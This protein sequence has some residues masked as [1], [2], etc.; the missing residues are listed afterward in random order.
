MSDQ[1][2]SAQADIARRALEEVCSSRN[3]A[4]FHE[5]YAES[6][7]D[8]VNSA[9]Y[10]GRAGARRS[11]AAYRRIF[12]DSYWFTVDEQI[13]DGNRVCSRFR[14]TGTYRGR[15]VTAWGLVTSRINNGQIEEDWAAMDTFAIMRQLGLWRSIALGINE[16]V[17]RHKR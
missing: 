2:A 12:G 15:D 1:F 17:T 3:E 6:F 16:I 10:H 11:V 8:H 13:V 7:V 9:E 5:L 14:L 4:G